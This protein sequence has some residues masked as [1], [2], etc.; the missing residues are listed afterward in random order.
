MVCVC[1]VVMCDFEYESGVVWHG[2]ELH[3]SVVYGKSLVCVGEN[4]N[5]M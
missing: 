2:G 1:Y 4:H 5:S 3:V